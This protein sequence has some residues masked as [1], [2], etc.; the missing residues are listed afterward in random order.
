MGM[1]RHGALP[2]WTQAHTQYTLTGMGNFNACGLGEQIGQ[3]R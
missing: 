1:T 2:I 3:G